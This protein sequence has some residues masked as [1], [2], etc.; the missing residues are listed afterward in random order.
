MRTKKSFTKWLSLGLAL[1]MGLIFVSCQKDN[2]R[3]NFPDPGTLP[4]GLV[5]TWVEAN[6]LSDTLVFSSND[7]AGLLFLQ[8]GFEI[9]N[10]NRLPV[11]GSTGY[12]YK[13]FSDSINL[14]DGLSSTYDRKTYPF[15]FNEVNLT[16]TIGNFSKYINTNKT[17]LTFRKIK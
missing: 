11:I 2:S 9:R 8:R 17:T 6:T 7:T 14:I 13:I 16:I 10:G 15:H 1:L 3:T 5:G 4:K 12:E